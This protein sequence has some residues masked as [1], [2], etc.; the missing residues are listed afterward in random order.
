M[1]KSPNL[2]RDLAGLLLAGAAAVNCLPA[3][4]GDIPIF[5]ATT[6]TQPGRYVVTRDI[7]AQG[8][9]IVL[10]TGGVTLDLNGHTIKSVTGSGVVFDIPSEVGIVAPCDIVA[11]GRIVGG[12]TGIKGACRR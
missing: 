9:V 4:N 8:D 1:T 3:A 2:C 10:Q 6:I 11:N 12:D 5:Q 7:T